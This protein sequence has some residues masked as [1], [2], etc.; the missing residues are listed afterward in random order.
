MSS[1][2]NICNHPDV[3]P[4]WSCTSKA[5]HLVN[6]HVLQVHVSLWMVYNKASLHE[7]LSWSIVL[8]IIL[9][10]TSYGHGCFDRIWI[11][12]KCTCT[13][14]CS[15]FCMHCS[16]PIFL[17]PVLWEF[18]CWFWAQ[19]SLMYT[20][21]YMHVSLV[22]HVAYVHVCWCFLWCFLNLRHVSVHVVLMWTYSRT[23]LDWACVM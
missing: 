23:W 10:V 22:V 2:A 4:L 6:V 14:T 7:V 1:F 8:R 17:L 20:Y 5:V 12:T 13:C 21:M 19:V 11:H 15:T 18:S 16:T 9:C 3:L